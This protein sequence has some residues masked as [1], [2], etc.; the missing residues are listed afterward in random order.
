MLFHIYL[1]HTWVVIPHKRVTFCLLLWAANPNSILWTSSGGFELS[2][3][4]VRINNTFRAEAAAAKAPVLEDLNP[5]NGPDAHHHVE[6]LPNPPTTFW[7][8]LQAGES[9]PPSQNLRFW[10]VKLSF[11]R[12]RV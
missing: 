3:A 12:I 5:N 4:K 1:L 2:S 11:Y 10:K 8:R 7:T 9:S 6:E